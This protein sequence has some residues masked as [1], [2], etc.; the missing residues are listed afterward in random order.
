[1]CSRG[2]FESFHSDQGFEILSAAR[3]VN[4]QG[5]PAE[6]QETLV[7]TP[8]VL[9]EVSTIED[10]AFAAWRQRVE[11]IHT[12]CNKPE[13]EKKKRP[14]IECCECR[15][16]D[17]KRLERRTICKA[18]KTGFCS[19]TCLQT[20]HQRLGIFMSSSQ[21]DP[22][23]IIDQPTM[24][25]IAGP[26]S[27]PQFVPGRGR[28]PLTSTPVTPMNLT[29]DWPNEG[30]TGPHTPP[31]P[32]PYGDT[33]PAPSV[34]EATDS[35]HNIQ[36]KTPRKLRSPKKL[37]CIQ[38]S[39]GDRTDPSVQEPS[40]SDRN[41]QRNTAIQGSIGDRTDPSVQEPSSSDRNI[42]R[43]TARKSRSPKKVVRKRPRKQS[44]ETRERRSTRIRT[45]ARKDD[46]GSYAALNKSYS[47]LTSSEEDA[48]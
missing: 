9:H 30:R 1:M 2:C 26:S 11:S 14:T 48:K 41:I 35:D 6:P 25:E 16:K 46:D 45:K 37:D 22:S 40:S 36:R 18:C 39:I 38:G 15:Y 13:T 33:T 44:P 7:H 20:N 10:P 4:I 27:V 43:R 12:L 21:Y 32:Y 34:Q 17:N 3:K 31:Y 29:N 24:D 47:N 42:Q 8:P 5:A 28:Y 23:E 19:Y